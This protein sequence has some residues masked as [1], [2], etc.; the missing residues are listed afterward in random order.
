[1][2]KVTGAHRRARLD[3]PRRSPLPA[4]GGRVPIGANG[5][6]HRTPSLR[7]RDAAPD[8][9]VQR[10]FRFLQPGPP[11]LPASGSGPLHGADRSPAPISTSTD[12]PV[13]AAVPRPVSDLVTPTPRGEF[14]AGRVRP[15]TGRVRSWVTTHA[16][17][18]GANPARS[19]HCHRGADPQRNGHGPG[20]GVGRP[21]A[22][23]DPGARTLRALTA[24]VRARHPGTE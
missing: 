5:E 3:R 10:A 6:G 21:G 23:Q 9:G 17:E 12:A 20:G 18:A 7:S 24:L 2:N 4:T 11:K 15:T 22:S 1:M 19:R 16:K 14:P 13:G 8:Q